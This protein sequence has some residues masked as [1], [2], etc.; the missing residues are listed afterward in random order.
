M[1]HVV[2]FCL[3]RFAAETVCPGAFYDNSYTT[4]FA[5]T[6]RLLQPEINYCRRWLNFDDVIC[7]GLNADSA[8]R[9]IHYM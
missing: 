2:E 4:T 9:P 6:V 3:L 7:Y 1:S 8:D 5:Q